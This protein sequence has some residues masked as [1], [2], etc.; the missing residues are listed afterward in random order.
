[1][2]ADL[3]GVGREDGERVQF[4]EL[5]S[6]DRRARHKIPDRL[7]ERRGRRVRLQL[8]G[9]QLSGRAN[10]AL[11]PTPHAVGKGLRQGGIVALRHLLELL[12]G[13][14]SIEISECTTRCD[15]N[16]QRS[17]RKVARQ[18]VRPSLLST[19][20]TQCSCSSSSA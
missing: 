15:K 19:G 9:R 13:E 2:L 10:K 20:G 3:R 16:D 14:R 11:K 12:D 1:M 17:E 4:V 8:L 18:I 7:A 6:D 5:H